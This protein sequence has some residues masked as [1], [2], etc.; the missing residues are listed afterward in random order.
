MLILLVFLVLP[1]RMVTLLGKKGQN[2]KSRR[3]AMTVARGFCDIDKC[4]VV[5]PFILKVEHNG[6]VMNKY[7]AHL[8]I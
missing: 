5:F 6:S 4:Q 7:I 3:I 8:S 2:Q 1:L